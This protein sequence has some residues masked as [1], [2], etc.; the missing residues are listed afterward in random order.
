MKKRIASAIIALALC[1]TLLPATVL[2]AELDTRHT[3]QPGA[4]AIKGWSANDGYDYIYLG[5]WNNNP[6]KWRV[7]S[8]NGDTASSYNDT[9]AG[10]TRNKQQALFML[11]EDVLNQTR[12]GS[13]GTT[14]WKGSDAEKWCNTF[15][16]GALTKT[17][18]LAVFTTV[19][20]SGAAGK[21]YNGIVYDK[22]YSNPISS[23][24]IF[25]LTVV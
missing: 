20:K 12:F 22:S 13:S 3:I 25:F 18:Q 14:K 21:E 24:N 4:S 10:S 6:V 5:N 17:E 15:K 16:T 7:L 8:A 19:S 11:S 2:A 9:P 1:L 23:A